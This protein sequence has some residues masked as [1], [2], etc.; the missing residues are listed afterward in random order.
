M[1]GGRLQLRLQ[2]GRN[3]DDTGGGGGGGRGTPASQSP[4]LQVTVRW[5]RGVLWT[6][7]QLTSLLR[8]Q[9]DGQMHVPTA[10][11]LCQVWLIAIGPNLWRQET[12]RKRFTDREEAKAP[13]DDLPA[14]ELHVII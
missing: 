12:W 4:R 6:E 2:N 13:M 8:L 7:M 9:A 1:V 11:T 10:W 14:V 3:H 5:H